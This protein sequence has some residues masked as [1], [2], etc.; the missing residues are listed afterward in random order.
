MKVDAHIKTG[1][2]ERRL[3]GADEEAEHLRAVGN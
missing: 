2:A 1:A 3:N